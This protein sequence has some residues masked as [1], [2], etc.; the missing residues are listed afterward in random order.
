MY[1]YTTILIRSR[2][3]M[4]G[5]QQIVGGLLAYCFTLINTGPLK[6]WQA[7]F[8]SYG[9]FSVLWGVFVLIW[10]PDSPMRAKCFT[11]P[12]KRLMLER[13]RTNLTGVQNKRFRREQMIE[14]LLDPQMYCY[15][16]VNYIFLGFDS[17]QGTL[18]RQLAHWKHLKMI[19]N[20]GKL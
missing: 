12:D 17:L 3:M 10:M 11:E 9:C 6:S 4:N 13:V 2:Y 5:G 20:P 14:A 7:I 16:L 15:C 19:L 1:Q 18:L 8:I